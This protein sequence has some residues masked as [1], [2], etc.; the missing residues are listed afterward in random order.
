MNLSGVS[1]RGASLSGV[2]SQGSNL[3]IETSGLLVYLNVSD[4]DS[5]PGSG[6]TWTDTQGANDAILYGPTYSVSNGG[7]FIFDGLNDYI[8]INDSADMRAE[9]GTVRTIQTW[10]K[11]KSYVDS[12]GIW[13]KQYGNIGGY[14]GYSLAIRT[15]NI[16]RLQM[17]GGT[18]NGGYNSSNN[19]FS[20]STWMFLTAIVRFG[21]GAG[22][23]SLL[24]KD[25]NSS[26]LIS[27]SNTETVI[28]NNDAP[29]IF[30]RDV[31]EGSD[32]ADIDIGALFV[33][34]KALNTT[35]IANNFNATKTRFGL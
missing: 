11:I 31:Q 26:P 34:N 14:D 28:P 25:D 29:F 23:P 32:Y 9:V 16:L 22:S 7:T 21:G 8:Q 19:V 17:N 24:Y 4:I 35:E 6:N 27:V 30:G 20:T 12:D 13:G 1:I 15:N 2:I 5:Y 10:V 33:Y 18:V 3:N